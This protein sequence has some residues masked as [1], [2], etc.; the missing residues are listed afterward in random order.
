MPASGNA[1]FVI[2]S[3]RM[4]FKNYVDAHK[5]VKRFHLPGKRRILG[6]LRVALEC[7]PMHPNQNSSRL[8]PHHDRRESSDRS[9]LSSPLSSRAR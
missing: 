8:L 9:A 2:F 1:S 6:T 3:D 7:D 5:S 4:R